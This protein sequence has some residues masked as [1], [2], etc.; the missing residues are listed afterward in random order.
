MRDTVDQALSLRAPTVGAGH[1]GLGP[2]FINE[3]QAPWVY[4]ILVALPVVALARN[5]RA[6]LLAGVERFF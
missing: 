2:G 3:H 5:V 1:V 4:T 6:L